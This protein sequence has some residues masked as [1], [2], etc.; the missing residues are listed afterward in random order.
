M[1]A[2]AKNKSLSRAALMA[3]RNC[4]VRAP[5]LREKFLLM[6]MESIANEA[7]KLHNLDEAKACLRDLGCDVN[8]KEIWTGSG[9]KL[10]HAD[11]TVLKDMNIT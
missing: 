3:V 6:Q 11:T 2:H 7:L 9:H 8:L 10:Q 1:N 5:E 4:V